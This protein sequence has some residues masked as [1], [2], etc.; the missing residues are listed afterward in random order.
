MDIRE[1]DEN[2]YAMR[3][4]GAFYHEIA[5]SFGISKERARMIYLSL[6]ERKENFDSWPPLKRMVSVQVQN[7][8]SAYFKTEDTLNNPQIIADMKM[9]DVWRIKNIGKKSIMEIRAALI[10]TGCIIKDDKWFSL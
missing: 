6:K 7:A 10:S 5:K 8:L 9:Y 4:N 3:I 2:I 1:R